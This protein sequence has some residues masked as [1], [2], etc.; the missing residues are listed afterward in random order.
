M[1]LVNYQNRPND[2]R[3]DDVRVYPR[4]LFAVSFFK[5]RFADSHLSTI[6]DGQGGLLGSGLVV[7]P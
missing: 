3:H 6:A 7:P 1:V 5:F 2:P 4:L